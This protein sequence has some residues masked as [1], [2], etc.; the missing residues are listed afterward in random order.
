MESKQKSQ[1]K[2]SS[3]NQSSKKIFKKKVIDVYSQCIINKQIV[4]PITEI[5]NNI[6][7]VLEKYLKFNFEGK[8]I[9]DGYVKKN[10]TKVISYSSGVI[11]GV[12]VVF[13]I[14]FECLVCFLVEGSLLNCVAKNITKAGIRAESSKES[15]SP[16]VVFISR[17]H[18]FS[19]PSFASIEEG[20]TFIAKVIGQ[21]FELN[22]TYVSV[23]G[24]LVDSKH[25][26]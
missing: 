24:E 12:N 19:H 6:K 26:L 11:N 20:D 13:E 22:D 9:V 15:P 7:E 1:M 8:C 14:V 17:D 10:S 16:F 18:H 3:P 4:L 5:G 23:I 25:Y 2:H 21:R